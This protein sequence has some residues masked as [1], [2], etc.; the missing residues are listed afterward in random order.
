[1]KEQ[2]S[3]EAIQVAE[4]MSWV[5]RERLVGTD[6]DVLFEERDGAYYTGHAPNYVKVYVQGENLHNEIR[7]VLVKEVFQDGV[8]GEILE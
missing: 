3:R 4:E 2:R 7:K 5:Y 6:L 1:M 8:L